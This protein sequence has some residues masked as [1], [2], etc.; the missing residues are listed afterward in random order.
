MD[1]NQNS[2]DAA[3]RRLARYTPQTHQANVLQPW[4][5][6]HANYD[7]VGMCYLLHC[8]PGAMPDKAVV[9]EHAKAVLAPDG[10]L[11]GA[12]ILGKGVEHTRLS[13]WALEINGRRG[14]LTSLDDSLEDLEAALKRAFPDHQIEIEIEGVIAMFTAKPSKSQ[15]LPS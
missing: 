6:A 1:L 12:T 11:F 13:R 5:L 10:A 3:S 2:L 4:G 9:F 14:I 7:S 8:L 15:P